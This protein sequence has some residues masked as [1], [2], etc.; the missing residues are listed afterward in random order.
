MR[1]EMILSLD[2]ETFSSVNI[3]NGVY[4]YS[5]SDDFQILLMSYAWND[6]PVQTVS[7]LQGETIPD[8][9][10]AALYNESIEKHAFNASFERVCLSRYLGLSRG[11]FIP[12][13][14]NWWCTKV[15]AAMLGLP[16]SLKEVAKALDL[17]E[18]KDEA[19]TLLINYFCKPCKATKANC[20]R[21]RNYPNHDP[22]KWDLFMKYNK[23]DVETERAI[24]HELFRQYPASEDALYQ[25]KVN[26]WADQQ[27]NDRG[28][29]IDLPMVNTIIDYNETM[30]AQLTQRAK[31]IT[32]LENP[33]S[34]MQLKKWLHTQGVSADQLT[35]ATI[36]AIVAETGS[37]DVKEVLGIR[38]QLGK[39]SV[40]KYERMR[41]AACQDS[42]VRGTLQFYGARTGRWAGRIIQ[43]QNLPQ[44]HY[45]EIDEL[46]K[47]VTKSNWQYLEMM[48]DNMIS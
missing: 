41:D 2:L 46:R 22:E 47:L 5:E 31:D 24:S 30:L 44:N 1:S 10:I 37:A 14:T 32:G 39:T 26:Y 33:N 42:R 38:Q 7:F 34:M 35:K 11:E 17:S 21:T 25:E 8:A 6:G 12:A 19:G 36:P 29:L 18:Q 28:V 23:Q 9:V 20:G 16:G 27:I 15:H 45:E 3:E 4:K 48:Y 40:T 13:S 43:P